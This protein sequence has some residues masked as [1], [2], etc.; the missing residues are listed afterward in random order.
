MCANLLKLD[1]TG[2]PVKQTKQ[3]Y[4]GVYTRDSKGMSELPQRQLI[5]PY[6]ISCIMGSFA[7][8]LVSLAQAN[9]KLFRSRSKHDNSH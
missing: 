3:T 8:P 4:L 1:L 9:G 5:L 2:L 6:T 7:I